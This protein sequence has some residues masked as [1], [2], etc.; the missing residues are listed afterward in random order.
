MAQCGGQWGRVTTHE[1]NNTR[2]IRGAISR[3]ESDREKGPRDKG[4]VSKT[5]EEEKKKKKRKKKKK[6]RIFSRKSF[7]TTFQLARVFPR[8]RLEPGNTRC[9]YKKTAKRGRK[10]GVTRLSRLRP[11]ILETITNA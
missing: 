10:N 5:T 1:A 11:L 2:S 9:G 8:Q 4:T 6:K 7:L 3:K